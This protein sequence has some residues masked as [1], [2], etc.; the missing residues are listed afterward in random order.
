LLNKQDPESAD[1]QLSNI[2]PKGRKQSCS[3]T[4]PNAIPKSI[5]QGDIPKKAESTKD[6][7]DNAGQLT[8]TGI[9]KDSAIQQIDL[10]RI[11]QSEEK[12]QQKTPNP[13]NASPRQPLRDNF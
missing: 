5:S 3:P 13:A 10:E 2:S 7:D 8:P 1:R 9:S 11:R 12:R 4:S 6:V